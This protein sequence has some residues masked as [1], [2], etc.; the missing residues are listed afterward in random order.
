M[1]NIQLSVLIFLDLPAVWCY[2]GGVDLSADFGIGAEA[3]SS[4]TELFPPCPGISNGPT[5]DQAEL[6]ALHMVVL[7][8]RHKPLTYIWIGAKV[9]VFFSDSRKC[10]GMTQLTNAMILVDL[11]S[12]IC[13]LNVNPVFPL[14]LGRRSPVICKATSLSSLNHALRLSSAMMPTKKMK[15]S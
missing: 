13:H 2:W 12:L 7:L 15:S 9:S 3:A 1:D 8:A 11:S 14:I 5:L 10:Y 4:V 6:I